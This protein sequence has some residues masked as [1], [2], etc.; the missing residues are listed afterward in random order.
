MKQGLSIGDVARRTGLSVSAIRFYESRGLV[1]PDRRP[2]GQ[3][4][5]ARADIR[6]LSFILVAQQMGL[7]IEEIRD[8]LGQLPEHRAPTKAD[9]TRISQRFRQ[10]L[11]DH[12]AMVERLRDRLDGCI[13][14]GCL[15]LKTCKL[16]N[17]DDRARSAGAGPRFVMTGE[18]VG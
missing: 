12:I 1:K 14:C 7:T 16:Y 17:P 3:R 6:R 15:S 10:R 18:K 11:D 4:E 5:F 13:G 2:S 9:W 8:V